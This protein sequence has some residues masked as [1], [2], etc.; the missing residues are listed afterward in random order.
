[1][2]TKDIATEDCSWPTN[3]NFHLKSFSYLYMCKSICP[4]VFCSFRKLHYKSVAK[5]SEDTYL[6][7]GGMVGMETRT[8][9]GK[10]YTTSNI[11]PPPSK[12]DAFLSITRK[13]F[14]TAYYLRLIQISYLENNLFPSLSCSLID[15]EKIEMS[16]LF[17]SLTVQSQDI[18]GIMQLSSAHSTAVNSFI[19]VVFVSLP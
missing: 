5:S 2:S 7:F 4:L 8:L 14:G 15:K 1:M 19:V 18:R 3:A 16:A 11:R 17:R 12:D 9:S 6:C 13:T 10:Y